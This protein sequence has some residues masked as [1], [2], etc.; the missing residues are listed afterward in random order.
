MRILL[1]ATGIQTGS[2]GMSTFLRGLLREWPSVAPDDSVT[3]VA[4]PELPP[5]IVDLARAFATVERIPRSGQLGRIAAQQFLLPR[6]LGKLRPDVLL[7]A[8]P[9]GPLVTRGVPVVAT[10]HDLRHRA[11]PAEFTRAR[12]WYR[13][14][15]W[16]HAI[17]R[18]D[19][20]IVNSA[21]TAA[22][23]EEFHHG[24]GDRIREVAFGCD[25]ALSWA[26]PP[27]ENRHAITFGHWSNKR[28]DFAI[29]SWGQFCRSYPEL[30]IPLEVVGA[31]ASDHSALRALAQ[32]E[33]VE[34]EVRINAFLPD[35]QYQQL[36]AS[37]GV[38]LMTS[39]LEG[40]G[41]PVLEAMS[42]GIPVVAS[43]GVGME[44]AGGEAALYA[45]P[46]SIDEFA[47][48]IA[49]VATDGE[50]RDEYVARGLRRA[51]EFT[52]EQT[53]QQVRAVLNEVVS[54]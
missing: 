51:A 29:R 50:T 18:A 32:A 13:R 46:D 20:L 33:G 16:G 31:P 30:R 53:V 41:F 43:R 21:F 12:R 10:V 6:M 35:D 34:S 45:S 54:L 23:V 40:F 48:Q 9:S 38:V 5:D 4:M 17:R 15:S 3:V 14:A 1:D 24:S 22:Q 28:P 19:R 44:T 39:T 36:F 26:V 27:A 52:W 8:D 37:A 2:G 25:H 11:H 7:T 49:R 42:L 47:T